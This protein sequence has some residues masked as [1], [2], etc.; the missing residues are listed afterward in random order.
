MFSRIKRRIRERKLQKLAREDTRIDISLDDFYKY[1]Q[2]KM[3]INA[4]SVC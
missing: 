1:Q 2:D 4:I 3:T